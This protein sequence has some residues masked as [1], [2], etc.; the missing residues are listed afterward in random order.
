MEAEP[1]VHLGVDEAPLV[2]RPLAAGRRVVLHEVEHRGQTL[3]VEPGLHEGDRSVEDRQRRRSSSRFAALHRP[4]RD[5][6]EP[7]ALKR[8]AAGR[9]EH[10]GDPV[11][12]QASLHDPFL[13]TADDAEVGPSAVRQVDEHEP[14]L[15][16]DGVAPGL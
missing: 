1:G 11:R 6:V 4:G 14:L 12:K 16:V 5:A 15:V 13:P 9:G 8:P 3:T 10:V 7:A 2:P